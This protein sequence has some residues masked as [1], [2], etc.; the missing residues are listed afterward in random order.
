VPGKKTNDLLFSTGIRVT[1]G[2][3]AK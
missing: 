2:N 3:S 1:F